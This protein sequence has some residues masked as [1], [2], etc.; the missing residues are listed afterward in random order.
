MEKQ[1]KK[2]VGILTFEQMSGKKNLGSCRIRGH[3]LVR[4][5]N[6]AEIFQ[7]GAKYDV[8][9]FQ[10]ALWLDYVQE[11]KGI[12]IL[13][14]CDPVWLE[15]LPTVD[16]IKNCDVVTTSTE[17]LRDEVK[18]FTDKPVIC[19]PDRQDLEFHNIQ[20]VHTGRA[21]KVVWFGYSHN[22]KVI[23]KALS[24]LKRHNLELTVISDCRPSYAKADRNVKYDWDNPSFDFNAEVLKN[25]IVI[26]PVDDSPRSIFKSLNK[27]YTAW[28]LGMPVATVPE[29]LV[30]FLDPEERKKEAEK[31]LKEVREKYDVKI[32]VFE[33]KQLIEDI[34]KGRQKNENRR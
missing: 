7:Q 30:R 29:E 17:T 33:F 34:R 32:S 5:W 6:E 19:I 24:L 13:D 2:T 16:I 23:D 14:L 28:A 8:V 18:K 3:W 10:K 4:Y 15:L 11:Y 22:S 21:K 31:R 26:M 1:D 25:D 27:T 12:K 20:K 9:I